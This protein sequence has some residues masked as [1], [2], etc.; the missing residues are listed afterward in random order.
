MVFFNYLLRS[1]LVMLMPRPGFRHSR[2]HNFGVQNFKK[3]LP[4]ELPRNTSVP[5]SISDDRHED[6]SSIID[7]RRRDLKH[8]QFFSMALTVFMV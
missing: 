8:I 7:E 5:R 6:E 3:L 2:H 1:T 4:P